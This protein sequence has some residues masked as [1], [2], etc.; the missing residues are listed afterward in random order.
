MMKKLI[1]L[2]GQIRIYSILDLVLL[3]IAISTQNLQF[4]GVILL[5]LSFIL[6]LELKHKHSYREKFPQFLWIILGLVG[7]LLYKNLVVIGFIL[8]SYLYTKKNIKTLGIYSS[9]FR[10]LQVYFLVAGITGFTN[11]L[12]IFSFVLLTLRNLAG[13][14]RDIKRD[15]QEGMKTLPIILGLKRDIKYLHLIVLL[16]TSFIWWYFVSIS[17]VWLFGI[18]FIQIVTYNITPRKN[19]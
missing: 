1:N 13:D 11:N 4:I 7:I 19:P 3:L 9:V 16:I 6:F 17:I 8:F 15:K 5:H 12:A 10:G 18:Y 2:L 14:L